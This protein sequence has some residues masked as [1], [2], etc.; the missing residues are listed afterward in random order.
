MRYKMSQFTKDELARV[1]QNE[2]RDCIWVLK[3]SRNARNMF[4]DLQTCEYV[5]DI[6]EGW[7]EYMALGQALQHISI[8][9]MD[10][11]LWSYCRFNPWRIIP[12]SAFKWQKLSQELGIQDRDNEYGETEYKTI[13]G[14]WQL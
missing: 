8:E 10:H 9:V 13:L 12:P 4:A 2:F 6:D 11:R 7:A 1:D 5:N 14:W 3:H